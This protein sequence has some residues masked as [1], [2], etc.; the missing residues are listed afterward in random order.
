VNLEAIV[1]HVGAV[2]LITVFVMLIYALALR[3]SKKIRARQAVLEALNEEIEALGQKISIAATPEISGEKVAMELGAVSAEGAA[4]A[5]F[6][7]VAEKRALLSLMQR[8]LALG[9]D[10]IVNVRHEG[11]I[12]GKT[13]W[14]KGKVILVGTAVKLAE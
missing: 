12:P 2:I 9:A 5:G 14:Q 6:Q 13:Q 4:G 1:G 8:A 3:E 7:R 10:A 11:Q